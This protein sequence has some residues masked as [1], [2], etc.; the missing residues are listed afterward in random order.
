MKYLNYESTLKYGERSRQFENLIHRINS[1]LS[2]YRAPRR[3]QPSQI[4]RGSTSANPELLM[5]GY[6]WGGRPLAFS[7]READ[8]H[9]GG[10]ILGVLEQKLKFRWVWTNNP[11]TVGVVKYEGGNGKLYSYAI[12]DLIRDDEV[13]LNYELPKKATNGGS[14]DYIPITLED[15]ISRIHQLR[16][17]APLRELNPHVNLQAHLHRR[18]S[19]SLLSKQP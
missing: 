16:G 6:R 17:V 11:R 13:A 7:L 18:K 2:E 19:I 15:F 9:H 3:A 4:T 1:I 10:D 8:G 5:G 12:F 14:E